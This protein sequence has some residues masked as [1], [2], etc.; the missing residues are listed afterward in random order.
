MLATRSP[1]NE[2]ELNR[3]YLVGPLSMYEN[4]PCQKATMTSG[5]THAT[6]SLQGIVASFIALGIELFNVGPSVL[7]NPAASYFLSKVP[8]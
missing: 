6:V 4:P 1:W 8:S 2:S 7:K 5:M 3:F